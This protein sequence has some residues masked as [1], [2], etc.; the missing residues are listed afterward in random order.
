[1]NL[2]ICLLMA[3]RFIER[4]QIRDLVEGY[5][6]LSDQAFE[7]TF[8][9]DKEELRALGVPVETGSNDPLFPDEIGYRI[10][11]RDFELPPLEFDAGELAALG[12]ASG[13]W[14]SARINDRATRAVAKLRAAGLEPD[15][16]RVAAFAPSVGAD[17]PGFETLWQATLERRP[18]SFGYRK[19]ARVVEP[20]RLTSRNGAWYLVGF[21]RGRGEGRSFKLGRIEGE[22]VFAGRPDTVTLP[23]PEVVEAHVASLEARR[24]QTAIVAV[25]EGT[26]GELT[27][28][29]EPVE[30]DVPAGYAAWRV[31][32]SSGP[33]NAGDL[34]WH[35]ADVIVLDPPDLVAAVR[36]H[37]AEVASWR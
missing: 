18:V 2:T 15:A 14:E 29:A 28:F 27:R 33:G 1:M 22:P 11:R 4:E 21:D 19:V 5:A 23:A 6:G 13:V 20:W 24:D 3:R 12:M 17:E 9:R 32:V 8:E 7:R 36:A 30:R 10:R 25:R 26:A 37:L 31:A 16:G 34:A 35:G